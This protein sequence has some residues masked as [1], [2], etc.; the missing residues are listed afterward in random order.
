M[1]SFLRYLCLILTLLIAGSRPSTGIRN[2]SRR[3]DPW[4]GT[5]DAKQYR[6]D[7]EKYR[8]AADWGGIEAAAQRAY[9]AAIQHNARFAAVQYLTGV[10]G[11]RIALFRYRSAL[12]ALTE[13]RRLARSIGDRTDEGAVLGNLSSLYLEMSDLG[14]AIQYAEDALR[15]VRT[16]HPY[17]EHQVR[18][19]LG[20]LYALVGDPR[21]EAMLENGIEAARA[22]ADAREEARGWDLLGD[23]RFRRGRLDAAENAFSTAFWVRKTRYSADLLF[24]YVR[25]GSLLLARGRLEEA[26]RFT[27][28]AIQS[29]ERIETAFPGFLL[30]H[31]RGQIRLAR[32]NKRGALED[33]ETAVRLASAWRKETLPAISTLTGTNIELEGRVFD[34]WIEAA[35]AAG[36]IAEAF[37]A[38]EENRAASLRQIAGMYFAKRLPV[39]YWDA[40]GK[41]R[42]E[43][44][45]LMRTGQPSSPELKRVRTELTGMEAEI[46]LGIPVNKTENFLAQNS[47][48]H[49]RQVLSATD[50][51]LS[52]HLGKTQSYVWAVTAGSLRMYRLAPAGKIRVA[53]IAFREAVRGGGPD[54]AQLGGELYAMLFGQLGRDEAS[55]RDW[56]LSADDA[57]FE[58]PLAALVVER[59]GHLKYLVEQHSLR[60]VPG[61]LS[62]AGGQTRLVNKGRSEWLGVGDPIYNTADARWTRDARWTAARPYLGWM[63][64]AETAGQLNRLAGS[65]EELRSSAQSWGPGAVILQGAD[66]TRERFQNAATLG[67]STIHLATHVLIPPDRPGQALI[68]FGLDSTRQPQF[69]TTSDVSMMHVPG[70]VI[71]MTG[72][73]SGTGEVQAGAGLLG[74]TRAWQM[75]GAR[76]VIATLWPVPDSRGALF[77]SFYWQL[78]TLP[79]AEA[80]RRSQVEQIAAGRPPRDWAAYQLSGGSLSGGSR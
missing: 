69:L 18:L 64:K 73:A 63:A 33:F 14:S 75:A 29:K 80:L 1:G 65:A 49:F 11:A 23:E 21:A 31:Q 66:A 2:G 13:A 5:Q 25:F 24:S 27:D 53:I 56:M 32:G 74:L 68:A 35:A 8:K 41:F 19:Q 6:L 22:A 71:V 37:Q 12:E 40:L 4:W 67:P 39:S 16:L 79:A 76:A 59:K 50:L 10:G 34:S 70:A 55:K 20:K 17:Y 28:I 51:F 47:L 57:L 26:A 9:V 61:A 44:A 30:V 54:G 62:L 52:F 77:S 78:H 60:L 43:Q 46:G 36:R 48:I 42:A 15:I 72:C 3:S 7:I 58:A 38:V 45:R